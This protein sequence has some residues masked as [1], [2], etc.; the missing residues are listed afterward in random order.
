MTAAVLLI[1]LVVVA[2]GAFNADYRKAVV[3]RP[4]GVGS[5]SEEIMDRVGVAEHRVEPEVLAEMF[6][7]VAKESAYGYPEQIDER[8]RDAGASPA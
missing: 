2:T 6:L 8:T 1:L 7:K 5:E 4:L 3:A